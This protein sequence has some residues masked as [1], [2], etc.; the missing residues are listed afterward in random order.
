MHFGRSMLASALFSF[1]ILASLATAVWAELVPPEGWSRDNVEEG[2]LL[3]SPM[4]AGG[5]QAIY[6]IFKPRQSPAD[7]ENWLQERMQDFV[8]LFGQVTEKNEIIRTPWHEDTFEVVSDE[9]DRIH[10][11]FF[12]YRVGPSRD[13]E[14]YQ[15]AVLI[16]PDVLSSDG[17]QSPVKEALVHWHSLQKT[18]FALEAVPPANPGPT[19]PDVPDVPVAA[20]A[21]G[22]EGVEAVFIRSAA[23]GSSYET[24]PYLFLTDGRS[25]L[26][27]AESP[28][29][30]KPSSRAPGTY[31]DGRW[32]R[33]P[34]GYQA[35]YPNASPD[36]FVESGR[37]S[38]AP[39]DL[40]L[41]GTFTMRGGNAGASWGEQFK[42]RDDGTVEFAQG[43]SFSGA[44]YSGAAQGSTVGSYSIRGWT[45]T[46]TNANGQTS[47]KLFAYRP[48][49]PSS[50]IVIGDGLYRRQ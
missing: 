45:I 44:G 43:A 15:T 27:V 38:P 5:N 32:S 4:D 14:W 42:F 7:S 37:Y 17:T 34:G 35:S 20:G 47:R 19:A 30:F 46:L 1:S 9:G 25:F 8:R 18:A 22:E 3:T 21:I 6:M 50:L 26:Q 39:P 48:N 33:S 36:D 28:L 13:P 29:D 49:E 40:R 11:H 24:V 10:G 23:I 2:V 16:W 41:N 31:G 12:A